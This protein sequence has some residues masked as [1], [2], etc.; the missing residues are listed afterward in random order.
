MEIKNYFQLFRNL[1]FN[2]WNRNNVEGRLPMKDY[3]VPSPAWIDP[4]GRLV[5]ASKEI[6]PFQNKVT[7]PSFFVFPNTMDGEESMRELR[8]IAH[9]PSGMAWNMDNDTLYYADAELG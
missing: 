1:T 7:Q 4:S 9:E 5:V 6:R 8:D 3:M 2:E